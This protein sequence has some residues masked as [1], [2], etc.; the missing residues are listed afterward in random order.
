MR[1]RPARSVDAEAVDELLCQL[2]YPQD[3][4]PATA[5]RL[6]AWFDDPASAAYI[7]E[8]D[9]ESLGVIAVHVCPFFERE[10]AWGRI[11]A[12]VV[13]DR[14]RGDGVG[15]RLVETAESF[16]ADRGCVRMEVTSSDRRPDAH[17]F[18]ERRGYTGQARISSRFLRDLPACRG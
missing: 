14:A 1:I 13:S 8:T 18:Y 15:S 5:A 6:H 4:R 7:A 3:D 12:L 11:T 17:R 16:A 2:G 10:G 9:D